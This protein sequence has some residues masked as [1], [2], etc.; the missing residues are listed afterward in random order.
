[1]A[2][3]ITWSQTA[4]DLAFQTWYTG[5]RPALLGFAKTYIDQDTNKPIP[6]Y[7][8]RNWYRDD[9]WQ[10]QAEKLDKQVQARNEKAIVAQRVK[11]MQRQRKV[12]ITLQRKGLKKITAEE[13]EFENEFAAL[14]AI[15]IGTAL[16]K[17]SIASTE[18]F[19][20]IAGMTDAQV[21]EALQLLAAAE[22]SDSDSDGFDEQAK[23]INVT[24]RG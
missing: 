18:V 5:G 24:P 13:F 16:E 14:R 19:D 3:T 23:I 15:E 9:D 8:L 1:M 11:M 4:K 2:R 22:T 6:F 20:D 7:T 17:S 21:L 12:G 10:A